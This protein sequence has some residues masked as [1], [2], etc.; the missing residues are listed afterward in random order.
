M[1]LF[2][3]ST[4]AFLVVSLLPLLV[5]STLT[6][7]SAEHALTS[8]ITNQ[9][10][11][12]ASTQSHRLQSIIDQ[13]LERLA[14]V[15]SRTQLRISLDRYQ[16]ERQPAFKSKMTKIINDAKQ[17]IASFNKISITDLDGNVLASTDEE[18]VGKKFPNMAVVDR[19]KKENNADTFF[20][21]S[22]WGLQIFL[23]GPLLLNDRLLGV[24][25]IESSADNIV[26]LVQDYS[27]L[28]ETGETIIAQKTQMG[29]ALF[30]TPIRF[31][32]YAALNLIV[33][34]NRNNSAITQSF[35]A[36][37]QFIED[38]VDYRSRHVLAATELIDSV[39][40]G[41]VVKID[42]DEALAPVV[43]L[44][45]LLLAVF[46]I[47]SAL[48][49]TSSLFFARTIA[50]P[51]RKLT[52]FAAK[53]KDG[54]LEDRINTD[55][56]G[57]IGELASTFNQMTD[58]LAQAQEQ[59]E[60]KITQL[61]SEIRER[62]QAENEL[63]IH[64]TKLQDL[65]EGQTRDLV[66]AKEEAELANQTKSEFLANMSHE[67]R[68]PL[69]AILGYAQIL[70]FAPNLTNTQRNALDTINRSGNHLLNL[71]NDILDLS[72]I[73]AGR[74][75]VKNSVFCLTDLLYD[76]SRMFQ[77]RCEQK[78]LQWTLQ[79]NLGQ[80]RVH[81]TGDENKIRQI[82]INLLGNAVKFTDAG[83]VS[84]QVERNDVYY[85]FSVNDSGP[86]LPASA[87]NVIFESFRQDHQ[88]DVK[89]GTGLGLAICSRQV[90]L[91]GGDL[92]VDSEPGR[93]ARFFFTIAI[94]QSDEEKDPVKVTDN[95]RVYKLAPGE[96]VTA[97]IVDDMV[98]NRNV[99]SMLLGNI[100]VNVI[101]AESGKRGVE[102]AIQNNPDI[103]FMDYRMPEM[104]G[105]QT[106][107]K[108]YDSLGKDTKIVMVT[109]SAF[110]QEQKLF[111][112]TE[113][114]AIITKPF[115]INEVF[116]CLEN[117]LGIKYVCESGDN[118]WGD[119]GHELSAS[120]GSDDFS[121]IK[122]PGDLVE[123]IVEAAEVNMISDLENLVREIATLGNEHQM[124]AK[125]LQKLIDQYRVD[126]VLTSI[127]GVAA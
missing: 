91:L 26:A 104:D 38:A 48:V 75:E 113:F 62:H 31:N 30:I 69:N 32:P 60:Q 1:T 120:S 87:H 8:Q 7:V 5:V 9:L 27:G 51:I 28:G 98:E 61:N 92:K 15:S 102:L 74:M 18:V 21:N 109:A 85:T 123:K 41:L 72:K 118:T 16:V 110:Y 89:G 3:K 12:L 126:E 29:D 46:L 105:I 50:N 86:G 20:T 10:T 90:E 103:I 79:H 124:Y 4:V 43:E 84:L 94:E 71:I 56:K 83:G 101:E 77:L 53:I 14:L 58:N 99:L 78:G 106:S 108:I 116:D 23:A 45:S 2:K 127:K 54:K 93:G 39:N 76:L 115:K 52:M 37:Q 96:R 49:I 6:L 81:V 121:A 22:S 122:V 100:G 24:I 33:P 114:A 55:S 36:K 25:I 57:E 70:L 40:W 119:G 19:G 44:R 112:K 117:L 17:S 80:S 35:S 65:I 125:Y 97:L 34:K 82:L 42:R 107:Q 73:E 88:G 13:N 66:K 68:T 11:S 59:L 67:I 111:E 47:V 63:R 95:Q 64:Q